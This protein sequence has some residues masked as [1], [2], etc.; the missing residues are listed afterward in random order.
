[1]STPTPQQAE[2]LLSQVEANQAQARSSDAWP[3]VFTFFS[4]STAYSVAL[5]AVGIFEDDSMSAIMT[6]AAS[7]WLIPAFVVYLIKARS[8]SRRSKVLVTVWVPLMVVIYL[9][10]AMAN[11]LAPGT[12]IPF[13]AAGLIWILAP[14]MAL[15]GLRR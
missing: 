9:A 2:E 3:I 7:A 15:F 6:I 14:A 13:I 4:L 12:W 8:W 1:M 10:G 5:V 11:S